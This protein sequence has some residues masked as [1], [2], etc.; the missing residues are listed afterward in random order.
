V[1]GFLAF[2]VLLLFFGC[3]FGGEF[4]LG[5]GC[6]F[7]F[8]VLLFF[9]FLFCSLP[10]PIPLSPVVYPK[11]NPDAN[12]SPL[13][14]LHRFSL[15]VFPRQTIIS[16]LSSSCFRGFLHHLLPALECPNRRPLHWRL[17]IFSLCFAPL[18]SHASFTSLILSFS[19]F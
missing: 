6:G 19:G 7:F 1:V 9:L 8:G 4:F 5:A 18:S 14:A 2:N 12:F 16:I 17:R 13:L 10:P 3:F 11:F 15:F